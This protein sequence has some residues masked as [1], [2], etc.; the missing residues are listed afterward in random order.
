MPVSKAFD[1]VRH[2]ALLHSMASM[3]IPD[4][5]CNWLVDFFSGHS[6]YTRF[7]GSTSS[8]QLD[9]SASTRHGSAIV[10]ASY[11]V[12]AADLTTITAGN[13]MF[14]YPV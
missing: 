12:S 14:K 5:V 4:D 6:R 10:P 11:V 7:H 9:I 2:S 1:T 8:G 13:L 3:N